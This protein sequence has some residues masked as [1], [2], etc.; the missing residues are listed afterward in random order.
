MLTAG[1][2]LQKERIRK[3]FTIKEIATATKIQKDYIEALENDDYDAF[4]S[5]VYAKGFLQNYAQFLGVNVSR[6]L[7]LY[8]RS[9]GE[10]PK[11]EVKPTQKPIKKR[12]F[13]LTPGVIIVS[14]IAVLL[15]I[16]FGYLIYQFYNFQKPPMLEVTNPAGNTTVTEEKFEVRGK[17]EPDMFVTVND[18]AVKVDGNGEFD[19]EITLSEG[20]NTI[21]VKARHPD[22]IGQ[23]AVVIR[24]VEYEPED[25]EETTDDTSE[26]IED[27][28]EGDVEGAA[29]ESEPAE[30][31][32][33][34]T[35]LSFTISITLSNAW[36]EIFI[37]G[38][39]ELATIVEPN[40]TLDY[41][42]QNSFIVT[43]GKVSTTKLT[44]NGEPQEL[45]I[46]EGGVASVEC[47]LTDDNQVD[48]QPL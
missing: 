23:D 19:V 8:R 43:S 6:V 15:L 39:Q 10:P 20:T 24:N 9:M 31:D 7:A 29:T 35:G 28:G 4:P 42:A 30:E 3:N 2:I 21:I 48:C 44:V 36:I 16:T 27:T 34:Q 14:V 17:T 26:E 45:F 12:Q 46:G 18:E 47:E 37:D 41:T 32:P 33:Q 25:A 38:Q 22:N 40:T 11:E 1:Q 13:R 5:A